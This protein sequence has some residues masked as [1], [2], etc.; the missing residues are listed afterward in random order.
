MEIISEN[1]KDINISGAL[2]AV[3]FSYGEALDLKKLSSLLGVGAEEVEV[4]AQSLIAKFA[5]S[6]SGLALIRHQNTLQLVSAPKFSELVGT[7]LKSEFQAE[8]TSAASETLAII[9]YAGPIGRNDMEYIRGVNSSF[10]IRNLMLRGLINKFPNPKRPNSLLYELSSDCFKHLG[11]AKINDLP[12]YEKYKT[13]A[14][15][16]HDQ[17]VA[18]NSHLN[19]V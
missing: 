8:L 19:E 2:E 6:E 18:E 15:R 4:A 11:L 7:L 14:T 3:L 17:S 9:A 1:K 13:L 16:L 12:E 5:S 10:T